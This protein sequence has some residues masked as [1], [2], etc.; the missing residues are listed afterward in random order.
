[1]DFSK[2]VLDDVKVSTVEKSEMA[3]PLDKLKQLESFGREN[4]LDSLTKLQYPENWGKSP[5]LGKD[6]NSHQ[7]DTKENSHENEVKEFK[8][9]RED[10]CDKEH[11]DTGV[12][13]V[14]KIVEDENGEKVKVV[15]PVFESSFDAQ[16][17]EDK[18][19]ST[20]REQ[21]KE[22]N[23]QLKEAIEKDP[24]LAKKFTGEQLEQIEND[25]TPDGYTWHHHE[26]K[27]KM[28]LVDTEVHNN[29]RHTGGKAI[30]GGG[31]ENR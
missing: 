18:L 7:L 3:S 10:L 4:D 11:P 16:L 14:E 24:E 20:D 13:Y 5:S 26:D 28:Q 6:L 29:T 1:M 27:G 15:V 19:Q 2:N 17:P 31:K 8:C 23:K 9:I 12:P 22:S 21:F 30:W 25:D